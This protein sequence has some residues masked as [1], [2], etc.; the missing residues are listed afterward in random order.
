MI[1]TEAPE[2]HPHD[3]D[4]QAKKYFTVYAKENPEYLTEVEFNLFV[5]DYLQSKKE[6][7]ESIKNENLFSVYLPKDE[8]HMRLED[9]NNAFKDLHSLSSAGNGN[10]EIDVDLNFDESDLIPEA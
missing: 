10:L 8:T 9:F 5:Q 6:L 3:S 7:A 4:V 1:S 2:I